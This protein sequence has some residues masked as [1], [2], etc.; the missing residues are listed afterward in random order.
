MELEVIVDGERDGEGEGA[1][2]EIGTFNPRT[3]PCINWVV[4]SVAKTRKR[5][6]KVAGEFILLDMRS[7][8]PNPSM[9]RSL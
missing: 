5:E 6:R 3:H 1:S 8:N 2:E 4:G 7:I 9:L